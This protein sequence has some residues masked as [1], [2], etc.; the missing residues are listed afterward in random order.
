MNVCNYFFFEQ[1]IRKRW[2]KQMLVEQ[3]ALKFCW[4][5]IILKT[6]TT[7]GKQSLR[8]SKT[9]FRKQ[10]FSFNTFNPHFLF[11]LIAVL[12]RTLVTNTFIVFF[13][14]NKMQWNHK[15]CTITVFKSRL[16]G[17]FN[18]SAAYMATMISLPPN[19]TL[20]NYLLSV[21]TLLI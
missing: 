19:P 12:L 3:K 8:W 9:I 13:S 21:T 6:T 18:G 1:F 14:C 7:K 17:S 2:Q 15:G 16:I 5:A 11:C 20:F 10:H 4:I